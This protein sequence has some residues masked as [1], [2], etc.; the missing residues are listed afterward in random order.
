MTFTTAQGGVA[1]SFVRTE[2]YLFDE[3]ML[4]NETTMEMGPFFYLFLGDSSS[5]HIII[6]S[7]VVRKGIGCVDYKKRG[8][9]LFLTVLLLKFSCV[10]LFSM[11]R[12]PTNEEVLQ[13]A[14][15]NLLQL[16]SGGIFGLGHGSVQRF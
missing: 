5:T 8:T 12:R 15:T 4:A 11:R 9:F 13:V 3:S 2:R 1:D 14:M 10:L 7:I 16:T 6:V